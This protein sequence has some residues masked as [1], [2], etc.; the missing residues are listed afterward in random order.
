MQEKILELIIYLMKEFD[1]EMSDINEV[2]TITS[3]LVDKGFSEYEIGI[4]LSLIFENNQESD[5]HGEIDDEAF[6]ILNSVEQYVLTPEIHGYLISLKELGLIN[7]S[8]IEFVIQKEFLLELVPA[9][10]SIVKQI[11][12]DL[13]V[14]LE[15]Y[16]SSFQNKFVF[17]GNNTI[18]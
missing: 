15:P 5:Y 14:Q 10:L 7:I 2:D 12:A 18:Q 1:G 11:V 9:K 6:R 17:S 13:I 16:E 3:D 4:A 8:D